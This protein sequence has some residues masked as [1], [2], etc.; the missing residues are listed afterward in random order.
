MLAFIQIGRNR[1]QIHVE[2]LLMLLNVQE[3]VFPLPSS[4]G[5]LENLQID[6][7]KDKKPTP[8]GYK[9]QSAFQEQLYINF[10][11]MKLFLFL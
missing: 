11:R 3:K 7:T 5:D 1:E 10:G 2:T 6:E 8:A 4:H 9:M